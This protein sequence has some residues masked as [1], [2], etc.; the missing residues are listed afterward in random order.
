MWGSRVSWVIWVQDDI[1]KDVDPGEYGAT[2]SAL[3][4][5]R[6]GVFIEVKG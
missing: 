2:R 3:V 1:M 4:H 5:H 6:Q